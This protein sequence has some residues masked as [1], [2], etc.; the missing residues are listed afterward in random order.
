MLGE[1]RQPQPVRLHRHRL[2]IHAR[3]APA[4]RVD[5]QHKTNVADGTRPELRQYT[6]EIEDVRVLYFITALCTV[7]AS[8]GTSSTAARA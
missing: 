7:I 5:R 6:D 8:A 1:L 4:L 2:H 3:K